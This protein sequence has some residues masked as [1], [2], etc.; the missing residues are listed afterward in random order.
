MT[1]FTTNQNMAS[2]CL[3]DRIIPVDITVL[4]VSVCAALLVVLRLAV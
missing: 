2:A 1:N 3:T 4:V